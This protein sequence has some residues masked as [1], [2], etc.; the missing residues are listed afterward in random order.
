MRQQ[1]TKAADFTAEIPDHQEVGY[2]LQ[3]VRY[4]QTFLYVTVFKIMYVVLVTA[5]VGSYLHDCALVHLHFP[6]MLIKRRKRTHLI[7]TVTKFRRG[8][9]T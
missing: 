8:V 9:N 3:H 5:A 4:A 6:V 2:L 1:W 7:F